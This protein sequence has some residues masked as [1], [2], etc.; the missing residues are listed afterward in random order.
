MISIKFQSAGGQ[1]EGFTLCGHGTSDEGDDFG[2]IVCSA[3][4]SAVYMAANTLTEIVGADADVF[5]DG[6]VLSFRLTSKIPEGQTVLKGFKLHVT[7]LSR[8]YS[9]NIEI[10]S[11][12]F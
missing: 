6:D 11:E 7:E 10:I 9:E 8:E 1:L 4:S 3:V 12:V 5:D 2:R